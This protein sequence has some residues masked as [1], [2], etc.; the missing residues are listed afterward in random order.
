MSVNVPTQDTTWPVGPTGS[1]RIRIVR[2]PN[3][4]ETL[5]LLIYFHGGGWVLGDKISHDRLVREL[6][7]GVR[8][9]LVFVDY[10]N[11]PEATYPTQNEQ[12]YAA[13][14]YAVENAK[15][16]NVD[17]S[18]LAFAGDSVGGN[19]TIAVTLMA[20]GPSQLLVSPPAIAT[21]KRSA[22]GK[23]PSNN[24]AANLRPPR[25]GSATA[26]SAASGR[27]AMAAKSLRLTAR[28]FRPTR[29]GDTAVRSKSTPSVSISTVATQSS[30]NCRI[31]A[32]SPGPKS[33]R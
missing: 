15:K 11:T 9:A 25:R 12:A 20:S 13:T 4:T 2:P 10:I 19:I 29:W 1:T 21:P 6:A 3:V 23:M 27:A 7:V 24:S 31:A 16:L 30:V 8:A 14:V 18:R 28:A 33:N 32:S 26:N 22:N 17:A 5:P